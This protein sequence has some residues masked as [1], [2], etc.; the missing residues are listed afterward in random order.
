M[1]VNG[2]TPHFTAPIEFLNF[3]LYKQHNEGSK[4][5][6]QYGSEILRCAVGLDEGK[7]KSESYLEEWRVL[8]IW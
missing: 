7:G 5:F 8:Y 2:N 6:W 3:Y 1:E 4:K